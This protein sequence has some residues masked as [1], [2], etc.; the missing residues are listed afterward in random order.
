MR[1]KKKF[2]HPKKNAGCGFRGGEVG[3]KG[4]GRGRGEGRVLVEGV[5]GGIGAGI[6]GGTGAGKGRTLT[7]GGDA[8]DTRRRREPH[9]F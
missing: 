9:W 4:R 6:R 8:A 2:S 1:E 5:G 3:R 7:F